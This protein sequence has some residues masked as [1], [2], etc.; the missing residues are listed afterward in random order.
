MQTHAT[1][2][3]ALRSLSHRAGNMTEIIVEGLIPDAHAVE[4]IALVD[5]LGVSRSTL[6]RQANF[7][8]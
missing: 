1:D 2:M 5:D 4:F 7:G 6:E 8:G 3:E